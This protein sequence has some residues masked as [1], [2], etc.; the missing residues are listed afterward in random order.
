M[1]DPYTLQF[2]LHCPLSYHTL[3]HST[4]Q[5]TVLIQIKIEKR[6]LEEELLELNP[7]A[8]LV[9]RTNPNVSVSF[10]WMICILKNLGV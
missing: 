1:S 7:T 10:L 2:R 8:L 4:T 9:T 3:T 5:M 6:N